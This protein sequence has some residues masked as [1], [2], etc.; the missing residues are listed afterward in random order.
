V[1][2]RSSTRCIYQVTKKGFTALTTPGIYLLRSVDT[3]QAIAF[4]HEH[5]LDPLMRSFR[6]I[7]RDYRRFAE[8][9]EVSNT[10]TERL[11]VAHL[12]DAWN[13]GGERYV[14][15][16]PPEAGQ[17]RWFNPPVREAL[18]VSPTPTELLMVLVE[19]ETDG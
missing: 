16:L 5:A 12:D 7:L 11:A 13:E 14:V 19:V 15:L 10:P 4:R 3:D 8:I 6:V 18:I 1:S 2:T 17:A 9:F